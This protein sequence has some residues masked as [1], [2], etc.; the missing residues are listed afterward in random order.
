[1]KASSNQRIAAAANT[2]NCPRWLELPGMII[3]P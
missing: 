3:A 2:F 1:M